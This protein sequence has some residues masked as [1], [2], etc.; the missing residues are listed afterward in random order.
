MDILRASI[1]ELPTPTQFIPP[2]REYLQGD[3]SYF[4]KG[5]KIVSALDAGVRAATEVQERGL[6]NSVQDLKEMS[7][8]YFLRH[9][10][11]S[12]QAIRNLVNATDSK[13]DAGYISLQNK[14]L[15]W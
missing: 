2:P 9:N 1:L 5:C 12:P 8:V 6:E 4:G 11:I 10:E 15:H 3:E 13:Y 7:K 14:V